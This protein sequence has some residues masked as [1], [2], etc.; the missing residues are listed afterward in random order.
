PGEDNIKFAA[1]ELAI[2]SELDSHRWLATSPRVFRD[3]RIVLEIELGRK[4]YVQRFRNPKMNVSRSGKARIFLQPRE[5]WRDWISS[6][7]DRFDFV[8]SLLVGQHHTSQ[9]EIHALREDARLIRIVLT[10]FVRLPDFNQ[11]VG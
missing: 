5:I 9:V 11:R 6:R 7:H 10:S 2:L 4:R 3:I 1:H 8:I